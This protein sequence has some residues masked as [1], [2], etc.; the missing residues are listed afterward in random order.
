MCRWGAENW[1]P[2]VSSRMASA[3]PSSPSARWCVPVTACPSGTCRGTPSSSRCGPSPK[4]VNGSARRTWCSASGFTC[5]AATAS[6]ASTASRWSSRASAKRLTPVTT[7]RTGRAARK[8]RA[9]VNGRQR[10]RTNGARGDDRLRTA[11]PRTRTTK[12]RRHPWS[13]EE[14]ERGKNHSRGLGLWPATGRWRT[15]RARKRPGV[16][17]NPRGLPEVAGKTPMMQRFIPGVEQLQLQQQSFAKVRLHWTPLSW[18][19]GK[20]VKAKCEGSGL[21]GRRACALLCQRLSE[22]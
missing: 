1:G 4:C 17:T 10:T 5:C 7:G 11:P 9:R 12:R 22:A 2:N 18:L 6:T 3:R 15:L 16:R 13:R 8:V 21:N 14:E 19:Q 20:G